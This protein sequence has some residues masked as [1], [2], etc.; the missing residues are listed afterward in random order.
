MV[1]SCDK[2][3]GTQE[4]LSQTM[5]VM[6]DV[7]VAAGGSGRLEDDSRLEPYVVLGVEAARA[8]NGGGRSNSR[9]RS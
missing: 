2:R 6:A 8:P 9:R 3:G 7:R 1:Q 4:V 5:Q